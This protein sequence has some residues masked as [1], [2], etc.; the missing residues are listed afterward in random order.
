M[1]GF[2]SVRG[3]TRTSLLQVKLLASAGQRSRCTP[4]PQ[5]H[6]WYGQRLRKGSYPG[7]FRQKQHR[8]HL[9][10]PSLGLCLPALVLAEHG[11]TAQATG[12]KL[13]AWPRASQR[14]PKRHATAPAQL[15]R[16]NFSPDAASELTQSTQI[17][18]CQRLFKATVPL[19]LGSIEQ[20]MSGASLPCSALHMNTAKS[21]PACKIYLDEAQ[22]RR[23]RFCLQSTS[24]KLTV[25]L[26]WVP[27]M[28]PPG[29]IK[30]VRK[31]TT[32]AGISDHQ[33]L[34]SPVFLLEGQWSLAKSVLERY[35]G[36]RKKGT[37]T[38]V[39]EH[40]SPQKARALQSSVS[41]SEYLPCKA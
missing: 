18:G 41:L 24:E 35:Q 16:E 25:S 19:S 20:C 11:V 6:P 2:S 40:P 9:G 39:S 36:N 22:E 7:W 31:K 21:P 14:S 5:K 30:A 26:C 28:P 27:A 33:V 12:A 34:P 4:V 15:Q 32:R 17:K 1:F 8:Q 38:E 37:E 3:P 13:A 29:K 23:N 10:S